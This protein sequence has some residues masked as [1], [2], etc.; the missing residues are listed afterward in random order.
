MR[1]AVGASYPYSPGGTGSPPLTAFLDDSAPLGGRAR[2]HVRA[3]AAGPG[4]GPGHPPAL[5]SSARTACG[6]APY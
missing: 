2:L 4:A 5:E 3:G 1:V 6:G